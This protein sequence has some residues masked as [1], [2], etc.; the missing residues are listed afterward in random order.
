MKINNPYNTLAEHH[1]F[2]CSIRNPIGL[3]LTFELEGEQVKTSW[4]PSKNYQGFEDIVHGG[5]I[6]TLMDEVAAWAI[7]LL[8]K[9]SGVTSELNVKYLRPLRV[10]KG[11]VDVSAEI[12]SVE[13]KLAHVKTVIKDSDDVICA[14]G[15][16]TY[17]IFPEGVAQKKFRYPGINVFLGSK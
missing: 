3:K 16:I 1:C 13:G 12:N 17:F 6:S 4:N 15:L 10:S 14:E 11:T 2:G 9:T 8:L 5:I 7:Q